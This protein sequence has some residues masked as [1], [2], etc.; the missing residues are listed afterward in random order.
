M[1]C[2]S[3][4][5]TDSLGAETLYPC[6]LKLLVFLLT[7]FAAIRMLKALILTLQIGGTFWGFV[8]GFV[9]VWFFSLGSLLPASP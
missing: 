3:V 8:F 4:N 7:S 6:F 2:N 5:L 9:F 1:F